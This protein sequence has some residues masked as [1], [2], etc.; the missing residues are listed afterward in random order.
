MYIRKDLVYDKHSGKLFY[1]PNLRNVSEH[2]SLHSE[3]TANGEQQHKRAKTM[4]GFMI[5]SLFIPLRFHMLT[6]HVAIMTRRS[7]FLPIL[8]SSVSSRNKGINK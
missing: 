6:I 7:S 2:Y 8:A 1:F 5:K 3:A 4:M